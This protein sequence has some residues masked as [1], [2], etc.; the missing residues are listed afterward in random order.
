MLRSVFQAGGDDARVNLRRIVAAILLIIVA[1]MIIYPPLSTGTVSIQFTS[2]GLGSASHLY[3]TISLIELHEAGV[4][5]STGWNRVSNMTI[6]LD[7][8][9]SKS[10]VDSLAKGTIHTG[11]YDTISITVDS[12][13]LVIGSNETTLALST[14]RYVTN[15]PLIVKTQSMSAVTVEFN[16]D[17]AEMVHTNTLSLM[18][19]AFS[20]I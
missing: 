10:L 18:L 3:V 19:K 20:N 9:D 1:V 15:V 14:E 6:T 12:A 4:D 17:I 2:K 5:N 11:H 7:L 8:M 13:A 16:F